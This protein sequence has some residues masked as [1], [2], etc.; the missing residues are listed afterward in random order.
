MNSINLIESEE[1]CGC[2]ACAK[3]CPRNAI[4]MVNNQKGFL[5]PEIDDKQ[6]I[7]CGLCLKVCKEKLNFRKQPVDAFALQHK[8]SNVLRKSSS[9]G[10]SRA[11]CETMIKDSG[12]VYGVAYT[13]KFEVEISRAK[14]LR[15]CDQFYGSKYIAAD[16]KDSF[17][18]VYKDLKSGKKVLFICTSCYVAGLLAYL[19]SKKCPIDNLVTVD[20]IC[21]GV[22]SPQIFKDYIKFINKKNDLKSINFR[23]KKLP[24]KYGTYSCLLV[25]KNGREEFNNLKSRLFLNLFNSN[26]CLRGCCYAC[27]Y[28]YANRPADITISDFWGLEKCHPEFYSEKGVSAIQINSEK[29]K[30]FFEKVKDCRLIQS[31]PANILTY[32]LNKPTNKSEYIQEFWDVYCEKGFDE[33]ARKYGGYNIRGYLRLTKFHK[34]W[35]SI[36]YGRRFNDKR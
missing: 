15:E 3:I 9:G 19:K 7:N 31:T 24:W 25:R 10:A 22:P 16:P 2:S 36:R 26:T 11:F 17:D 33:V 12:V 13:K 34:I 30:S 18:R 32:N 8:D 28:V 20:L 21:H 4:T 23:S 6:C 27:P 35:T 1:C 29:G 14:N 5:E